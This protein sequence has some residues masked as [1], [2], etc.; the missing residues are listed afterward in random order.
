[1]FSGNT[2]TRHQKQLQ[3]SSLPSIIVLIFNLPEHDIG[4]SHLDVVPR[5]SALSNE[6]VIYLSVVEPFTAEYR[7]Q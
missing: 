5:N 3:N 2:I 6:N 1:M 7:R 4:N